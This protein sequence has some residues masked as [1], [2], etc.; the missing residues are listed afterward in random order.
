MVKDTIEQVSFD[1]IAGW[2]TEFHTEA[3]EAFLSSAEHMV[4]KPYPVRAFDQ[5]AGLTQKDM[6]SVAQGAIRLRDMQGARF[7]DH[8]KTFFESAF[9]PVRIVPQTEA[10]FV[11]GYFEPVV[12]ASREKTDH[13]PI[14][15]YRKPP[16]L[17]K[18]RGDDHPAGVPSDFRY[19]RKTSDG[20]EPF[21]DREAITRGALDGQG[22]ELAY[23]ANKVDAFFIHVQ[24]SARLAMTDGTTLRITFAAKSGHPY[25]SVAKRLCAEKDID[26]AD[27]T[28]DRLAQWMHDHPDELDALLFQNRSFIFFKEAHGLGGDD[29]PVGAAKVPLIPG[30][31][32]AVDRTLHTFG[33]PF[34]V[35]TKKPLDGESAPFARLMVAHD[36][37][38]AITGPARGDLFMGWGNVAGLKAGRVRH[39]AD[40]IMLLPNPDFDAT[41]FLTS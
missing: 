30:R 9:R 39:E 27:M 8:A 38:S 28:A 13:F 23:V 24:G 36:T 25:T 3:L 15:L 32:L 4:H 16:D 2:E 33:L 20:F 21:F 26:P 34:W 35:A 11:T 5:R 12:Q 37:G 10:G 40:M 18:L 19:A 41:G 6:M 29:G 1:A 17:V 31:S 7:L 22:L 14:P